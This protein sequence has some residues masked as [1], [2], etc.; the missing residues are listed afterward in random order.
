MSAPVNHRIAALAAALALAT[1]AS[2]GAAPAKQSSEASAKPTSP[3]STPNAVQGFSQNQ[4]KPIQIESASLEV[5]DKDKMATFAGDVHVVQGDTDMRCKSLVVFY[6]ETGPAAGSK[7]APKPAA[8]GPPPKPAASGP[9]PKQ[10]QTIKRLVATGDVIV[11]QK[12]QTATGNSGVY[13]IRTSTITLTGNVTLTQGPNVV[14]GERLMVNVKSGV[15]RM[16]EGKS[17]QGVRAMFQSGPSQPGAPQSG[18]LF[19]MTAKPP[20]G[21]AAGE[22]PP[23]AGPGRPPVRVN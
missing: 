3:D 13:D 7:A 4:G 17:G 22:P 15:S 21:N 14:R 23:K 1:M 5:R 9:P 6:D 19:P 11:V 18:G 20:E 8:S 10:Q 16:E 12:E 2:A